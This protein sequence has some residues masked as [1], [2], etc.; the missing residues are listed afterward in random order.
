[1]RNWREVEA[2]TW[3]AAGRQATGARRGRV[4]DGAMEAA[5]PGALIDLPDEKTYVQ[6]Q[7]N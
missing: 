3:R 4:L 1:V 7:I 5:P 6:F 2:T